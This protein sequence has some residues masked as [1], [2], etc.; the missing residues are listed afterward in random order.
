MEREK[1]GEFHTAVLKVSGALRR[2]VGL[3]PIVSICFHQHQAQYRTFFLLLLK[4]FKKQWTHFVK[5]D[6]TAC[7]DSF[8]DCCDHFSFQIGSCL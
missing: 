3:C 7:A 4:N 6:L 5:S 1:G 8:S 2:S